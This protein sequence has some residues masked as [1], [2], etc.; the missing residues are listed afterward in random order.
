MKIIRVLN[1]RYGS[2]GRAVAISIVGFSVMGWTRSTAERLAVARSES[3][4]VAVLSPI[5][6]DKFQQQA[7]PAAALSHS[8]RRRPGTS[9]R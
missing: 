1:R 6:V 9:A 4:V 5:C 3:A 7:N 2:G 8:R